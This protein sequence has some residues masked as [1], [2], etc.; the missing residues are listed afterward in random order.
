MK[1]EKVIKSTL[2]VVLVSKTNKLQMLNETDLEDWFTTSGVVSESNGEVFGKF[3]IDG[4]TFT[5]AK[6][7]AHKCPRCWKFKAES[8]DGLCPRCAEVLNA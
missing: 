7:A 4:D 5:I 3:E 2:E 6:A 1:K 8:E